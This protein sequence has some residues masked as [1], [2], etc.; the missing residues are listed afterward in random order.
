MWTVGLLRHSLAEAGW[1]I[2]D[3]LVLTRTD[4]NGIPEKS[5]H[6]INTELGA[7]K[8]LFTEDYQRF[9]WDTVRTKTK[10]MSNIGDIDIQGTRALVAKMPP[11]QRGLV[12]TVQVGAWR[13]AKNLVHCGLRQYETC[14]CGNAPR[15]IKHLTLD[16]PRTQDIRDASGLGNCE[17]FRSLPEATLEFALIELDPQMRELR[18][19]LL[20][21]EQPQPTTIG[22]NIYIY[23]A[24]DPQNH[25]TATGHGEQRLLSTTVWKT[26]SNSPQNWGGGSRRRHGRRYKLS[27]GPNK[28]L[29]TASHMSETANT[30]STR[31]PGVPMA[32]QSGHLRPS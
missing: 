13:S 25:Q 7:L 9:V 3:G 20:E 6:L 5:L 31:Q 32:H 16:C 10:A 24:T 28:P 8:E 22:Q 14:E 4:P 2:S 26:R 27:S 29:Q 21:Y 1:D 17:R 23:G 15:T 12:E 19:R 18:N 11:A 30:P